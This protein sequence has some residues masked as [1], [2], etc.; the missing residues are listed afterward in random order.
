[1]KRVN[2]NTLAGMSVLPPGSQHIGR[3]S[4][5]KRRMPQP[6]SFRLRRLSTNIAKKR[7][8]VKGKNERENSFRTGDKLLKCYHRSKKRMPK[9]VSF[10]TA[11][12]FAED[13]SHTLFPLSTTR[14]LIEHAETLILDYIYQ[15]VLNASEPEHS[16]LSQVR[17]YSSKQGFH[18][19]RTVKFDPVAEAF[20]YDLIF[21]NKPLFHT[22]HMPH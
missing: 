3:L 22:T 2:P 10:N 5:L 15:H 16:F 12:Y 8:I 1:M 18:L 14:V 4:A 19:R 20:I 17:C 21:R 11:K 7:R 6:E 13:Y 9:L